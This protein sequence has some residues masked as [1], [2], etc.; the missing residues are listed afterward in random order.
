MK[1]HPVIGAEIIKHLKNAASIIGGTT[2]TSGG[3]HGIPDGLKAE[4]IPLM[5]RIIQ[6]ADSTTR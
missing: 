5:A 3:R 2:T 1:Q 4:Q 6:M